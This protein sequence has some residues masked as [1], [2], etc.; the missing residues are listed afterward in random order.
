M[1]GNNKKY[2]LYMDYILS[3]A[4]TMIPQIIL[5]LFKAYPLRITGD[6]LF[7]FYLPAK[8]AGL[9]WAECMHDYRYYGYGFS[10]FLT[11]LFRFIDNPVVLYKI[12]LIIVVILQSIIPIISCYLLRNYFKVR[13]QK[14]NVL[15]TIS[16]TYCVSLY[17]SYMYNEHIYII[18]VWLSF[19]CIAKLVMNE[20]H[21][22][23]KIGWS[24]GL[25][26]SFVGALTIH[27]RAMTLIFG[28]AVLYILVKILLKKNIGYLSIVSILYYIGYLIDKKIVEWNIAF[29]KFNNQFDKLESQ[30]IGN[31]GVSDYMSIKGKFWEDKIFLEAAKDIIV[32]NLN[33]WNIFT[34]GMAAFTIVLCIAYLR[35]IFLNEIDEIDNK[36]IIIGI[37]SMA[38]IFITIVGLINSWGW[39]IKDAYIK[40][41]DKADS[42][43]GLIYLRYYIAYYPACMLS[44][45]VLIYKKKDMYW[46]MFKYTCMFSCFLMSLWLKE[47]IPFVQNNNSVWGT[48]KYFSF[49]INENVKDCLLGVL[50][51][52]SI[53]IVINIIL[54]NKKITVFMF[55][56]SLVFIYQYSYKA[57]IGDGKLAEINYSY[58]DSSYKL[59]QELDR[60]KIEYNVYV[61]NQIIKESSQSILYQAQFL[62][63]RK[64]IISG[65]PD[66]GINNVIFLTIKKE[67]YDELINNGYIFFE[68]DDNEYIW[69]KGRELVER[70]E[71]LRK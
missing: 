69:V 60:Q 35:K 61:Q 44:V 38:C 43:R 46:K 51:V 45:L 39:G 67:G 22:K 54:K 37:F 20:K 53:F 10:I 11:P 71:E 31:V 63:M 49:K 24:I 25:A 2:N 9:N 50:I 33:N 47:V 23:R 48:I 55:T 6:E 28:Y 12:V 16:C 21:V 59:I 1:I 15:I 30:Q 40:G 42:L 36:V 7:L 56:L 13:N 62:N 17:S 34:M 4:F 14:I 58:C 32:S 68:L 29:L 8:L 66:E 26:A 64:N 57:L 18:Y 52:V 41:N 19:L 65:I 70:I 3:I 27:Q 5:V